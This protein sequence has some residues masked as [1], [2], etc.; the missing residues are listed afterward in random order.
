MNVKKNQWVALWIGFA[1]MVVMFI[2]YIGYSV[3]TLD[4]MEELSIGYGEV[5]LIASVTALIGGLVIPF[6][7]HFVDKYGP[8]R[9][10]VIGLFIL[11]VGQIVFAIA[12]NFYL[13]LLSRIL[14]GVG[15]GMLIIAPYTLAILWFKSSDSTGVGIGLM[16]GTDGIGT[17]VAN[18][19]LAMVLVLF[20]WR[21]G[22]LVSSLVLAVMLLIVMK[23]LN[24]PPSFEKS[25]SN[26]SISFKN[27]FSL[28][29]YRNVIGGTIYITGLFS[30]FS[31]AAYWIPTILIE[32][33]GWSEGVSGFVSASFALAGILGAFLFGLYSDKVKKRKIFIVIASSVISLIFIGFSYFYVNENYLLLAILLPLA[34]IFAYGGA[35]VVYALVE[36]NVGESKAGL[37]NGIVV[38]GGMIIGG[39]VVPV[40]IGNIKDITGQYSLGFLVIAIYLAVFS[41]LCALLFKDVKNNEYAES[42]DYLSDTN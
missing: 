4:I 14:I 35:P 5:S 1:T 36:E 38:G 21:N 15:V 10:I 7:G 34:G 31:L 37:A 29:K 27:F 26:E 17:V 18:Y 24:N 3:K 2:P 13:L 42:S 30:T 23:F 11:I 22:S 19:L 41:I 25:R 20:G 33:S 32:E 16:L 12:P 39:L 8:K 6:A 9:V 28:L 40:L